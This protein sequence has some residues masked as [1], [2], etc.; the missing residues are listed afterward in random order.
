VADDEATRNRARAAG[1]AAFLGKHEA[2]TELLPAAIRDAAE[3][4]PPLETSQ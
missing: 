2:V 4:H 1:A 3:R